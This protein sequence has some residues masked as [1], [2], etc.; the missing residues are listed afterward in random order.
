MSGIFP[1]KTLC[2]VLCPKTV[3]TMGRRDRIG[4]WTKNVKCL[5]SLLQNSTPPE[6]E[7]RQI[8]SNSAASQAASDQSR[9]LLQ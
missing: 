8:L 1:F 7:L 9:Q 5:N 2:S 3:A 4:I 6:Y